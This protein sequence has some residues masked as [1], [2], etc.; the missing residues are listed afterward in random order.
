[1]KIIHKIKK[2]FV[3]VGVFIG[4][5]MTKA[6]GDMAALYGPPT[7]ELYGVQRPENVI[8]IFEKIGA[9]IAIPIIL[10]VG[11]IVYLKK[12]KNKN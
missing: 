10:I 6:F 7:A 8:S 2:F 4:T 9:I 1:M 3:S 5:L 12:K 11:V